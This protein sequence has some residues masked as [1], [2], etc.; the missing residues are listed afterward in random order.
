MWVS[1]S[2]MALLFLAVLYVLFHIGLQNAG[3]PG[4]HTQGTKEN[5]TLRQ[6]G[7]TSSSNKT[8]CNIEDRVDFMSLA[9]NETMNSKLKVNMD[10]N[11]YYQLWY[12]NVLKYGL[13]PIYTDPALFQAMFEKSVKRELTKEVLHE[14]LVPYFEKEL[15]VGKARA[16]QAAHVRNIDGICLT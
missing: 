2:L 14:L 16:V 15:S 9:W 6:V 11:I 4:A 3:A 12:S 1:S 10:T 8:Q 13:D 5:I 7:P